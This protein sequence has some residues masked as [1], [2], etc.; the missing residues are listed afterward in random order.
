MS[1][2]SYNYL[3]TAADVHG[4]GGL[5][6]RQEDLRSMA[7]RLDGLCPEA[8]AETR[9]FVEGGTAEQQAASV[10]HGIDTRLERLEPLWKAVEWR[11]SGDWGE[12]QLARA[13]EDYRAAVAGQAA[14]PATVLHPECFRPQLHQELVYFTK[15]F[16]DEVHR[17]YGMD[18][19]TVPN[20]VHGMERLELRHLLVTLEDTVERV[21]EALRLRIEADRSGAESW[22]VVPADTAVDGD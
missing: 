20:L 2:G 17:V 14:A 10:F 5:L 6:Q 13:L 8:A 21:R 18:R 15:S 9:L 16:P 7:H 12:D 3:S 22:R 1:G 19:I 4:I 11:D